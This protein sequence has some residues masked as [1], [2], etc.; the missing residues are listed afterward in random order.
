MDTLNLSF[1]N[2]AELEEDSLF[3]GTVFNVPM[4]PALRAGGI[5]FSM[6][7]CFHAD[8]QDRGSREV[9]V[10]MADG[11]QSVLLFKTCQGKRG[12]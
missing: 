7:F 6:L 2:E 4:G 10:E 9:D 5:S 11:Q 12:G 3:H 8:S 1:L